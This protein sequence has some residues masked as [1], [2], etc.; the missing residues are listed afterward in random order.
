MIKKLLLLIICAFMP[1]VDSAIDLGALDDVQ[2]VGLN[3]AGIV[4]TIPLP[5]PKTEPMSEPVQTTV[6]QAAEPVVTAAPVASPAPVESVL[7]SNAISI[8]G[9]VIPIVDVADTA[10]NA[11]DHVNK[12]GTKF[13]YGHNSPAVFG[14]LVYVG[15][16]NVFMVSY[17][18]I[19][20]TYQVAE[21]QIFEK[22]SETTLS[23]NGVVYRMSAVA[24]GKGRYDMVLMTCYGTMYGNGD[25]SHRLVIF[26]NRV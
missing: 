9:H 14:D 8:A 19:T 15:V 7:P 25:A 13:L 17:G 22:A 20:S 4:Q 3:P 12:Y 18:G 2:V 16:G 26:A 6:A 1:I 24:N 11:G 10:I 23:S 5:E 21:V